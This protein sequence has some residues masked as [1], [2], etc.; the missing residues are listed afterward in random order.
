MT[1]LT[2]PPLSVDVKN[3]MSADELPAYHCGFFIRVAR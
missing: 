2:S 3:A 1:Q